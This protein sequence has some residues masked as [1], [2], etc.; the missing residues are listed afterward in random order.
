MTT[1]LVV[2]RRWIRSVLAAD[3]GPS[4]VWTVLGG[5]VRARRAV[6]GAPYP[7]LVLT[8]PA[9]TDLLGV[10]GTRVWTNLLVDCRLISEGNN[11]EAASALAA[12]IDQL[13]HRGSGAPVGG[14][15]WA[16]VREFPFE[17]SEVVE[18]RE[19]LHVG[20]RYRLWATA[21]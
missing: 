16:C 8:V 3:S 14:R 15:V 17:Y 12:R 13:L 21:T 1:E 2:A 5:R 11:S 10:G 4:G 19:Y 9:A 6:Q 18:G 20:G 7:Q